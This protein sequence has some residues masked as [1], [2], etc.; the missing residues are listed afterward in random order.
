[1]RAVDRFGECA[2]EYEFT[3]LA[4]FAGEAQVFF[5]ERDAAR[6]HIVHKFVEAWRS[7]SSLSPFRMSLDGQ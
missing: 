2:C 7:S 4:R 1:M 5:A 3:P 6:D